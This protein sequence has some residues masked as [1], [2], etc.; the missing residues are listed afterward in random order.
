MAIREVSLQNLG[1]WHPLAQQK[2]VIHESLL[3]ENHIFYQFTKV[4][5]LKSFPLHS[6]FS[7]IP[8]LAQMRLRL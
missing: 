8:E 6:T 3:R 7:L 4:F 5:S 1:V 2:R